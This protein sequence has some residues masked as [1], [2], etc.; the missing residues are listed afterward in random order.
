M[1]AN[2]KK[3]T[4]LKAFEVSFTFSMLLYQKAALKEFYWQ[5]FM[6]IPYTASK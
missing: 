4:A 2:A 3:L 1:I 6:V 5:G